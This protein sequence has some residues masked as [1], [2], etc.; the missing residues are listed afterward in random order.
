MGVPPKEMFS[1]EDL[2]ALS[3]EDLG[4][5]ITKVRTRGEY[6]VSLDEMAM[7]MKVAPVS[8]KGKL[9]ELIPDESKAAVLEA[10][11]LKYPLSQAE[12]ARNK[13]VRIARKMHENQEITVRRGEQHKEDAS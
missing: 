8:L 1:F 11:E 5:V 12:Y 13:V 7:A 10:L 6:E 2:D 4:R 3:Q 9:L